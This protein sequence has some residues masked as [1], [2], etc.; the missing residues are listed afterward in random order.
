VLSENGPPATSNMAWTVYEG[1]TNLEGKR[2]RVT[3]SYDAQPLFKLSP[4][5]YLLAAKWGNA[6]KQVEFEVKSAGE[7]V[8]HIV[9]MNAGLLVLEALYAEGSEVIKS[10]MAW[11]V[12]G[13][14][15]DLQGKQPRITYSYDAKPTFRLPAGKF[16]II[17]KRGNATLSREIAVDEG[18][19]EEIV[20]NLNAGL[21]APSGVLAAGK[22]ALTKGMAWTIFATEKNLEGKRARITYS[23]DAKP[24]FT[25][26]EG[27]YLLV[28]KNGNAEKSTEVEIKAGKRNDSEI[29]LDAGQVK[30]V[31]MSKDGTKLSKGTA[32]TI[33]GAEKNL[34]GNRTRITYSYDATPIFT[35]NAGKYIVAFKSGNLN[36]EA[37]LEVKA[38]DAKQVDVKVD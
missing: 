15:K 3:Y 17:A 5:K 9:N 33:F 24:T 19:R 10:G 25:L 26:T 30:L 18:K 37:E 21:L 16:Q 32:W 7:A 28:T 35:L 12:Y 14:E 8:K 20:Y 2:K 38:G 31:A 36:T 11:T 29:N 13:L 27:K 4:G 6:E 34:E 1:Q 23:Y 22:P